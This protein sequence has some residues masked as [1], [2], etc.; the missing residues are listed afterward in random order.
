MSG[1]VR[2]ETFAEQ[3]LP[4]Y[5]SNK[6]ASSSSNACNTLFGSKESRRGWLKLP[7]LSLLSRNATTTVRTVAQHYLGVGGPFSAL[8]CT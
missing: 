3:K 6:G 4:T 8:R 2:K 7:F 1:E 5:L